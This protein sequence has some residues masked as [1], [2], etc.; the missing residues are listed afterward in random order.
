MTRSIS[1]KLAR[2][3]G[4]QCD[5][6][7]CHLPVSKFSRY[8]ERHD[9]V[10]E[11]TGDPR[12][13]TVRASE[14]RPYAD[15]AR[16]LIKEQKEHPAISGVLKFLEDYLRSAKPP[17][18]IHRGSMTN[19]RVNHWL[20]HLHASGVRPEAIFAT[21]IGMMLLREYQPRTFKSDRHF[22]HQC[23]VRVLRLAP[24]PRGWD[25]KRRYPRI[26]VGVREDLAQTLVRSRLG[27]ICWQVAAHI[28]RKT[29]E[30]GPSPQGLKSFS[31]TIN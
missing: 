23:I 28:Q 14:V 20:A 9:Q 3:V 24:A 4:R 16:K 2:R 31:G 25:M 5:V 6:P 11:R 10:N 17:R 21:L 19:Q 1:E 13:H 12:G 15:M 7:W 22:W 26:T 27:M 29:E 30:N 18:I 8:C